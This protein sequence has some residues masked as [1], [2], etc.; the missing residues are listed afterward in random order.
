MKENI[1]DDEPQEEPSEEAT[2]LFEDNAEILKRCSVEEY[3]RAFHKI[4]LEILDYGKGLHQAKESY[5]NALLNAGA[6]ENPQ[7]LYEFIDLFSTRIEKIHIVKRLCVMLGLHTEMDEII[8]NELELI[9]KR[10]S[11]PR[12]SYLV[13]HGVVAGDISRQT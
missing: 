4:F 3:E 11:K 5:T 10:P 9:Y 8:S 1:V 6:R 7:E 2:P 13:D 12:Q